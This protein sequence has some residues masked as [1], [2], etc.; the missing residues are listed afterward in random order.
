MHASPGSGA[1]VTDTGRR[2]WAWFEDI[3]MD[4]ESFEELGRDFEREVPVRRGSVGS[5][6]AR[7]FSQ[8]ADGRFRGRLATRPRPLI[9]PLP[10]FRRPG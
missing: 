9:Q 4:A 1:P 10:A 8:R 2:V 5:A 3:E 6:A 7:L